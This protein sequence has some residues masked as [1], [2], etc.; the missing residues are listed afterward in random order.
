MLTSVLSVLLFG[1][2]PA[3]RMQSPDHVALSRLAIASPS[4]LKAHMEQGLAVA[5]RV[6]A[7]GVLIT[8]LTTGQVLYQ[9]YSDVRRPMASLTKLMTAIVIV[10][11]HRLDE[12]VAV[13]TD[14]S[15]MDGDIA[16]LPPGHHFT[17]GDLLSALLIPS[18]NDAAEALAR[19]HSG[20]TEAFV[21]AMNERARAIGLE[22]TSFANPVG[23]DDLA[24]WSTPR[25]L[26]LLATFALR[27][28]EIKSRLG[29]RGKKILS[30]E[31]TEIALT[32]THAFLHADTSVI[33]GKTGTTKAAG[34]CLMSIVKLGNREYL[35]I[36][37]RSLQRYADMRIILDALGASELI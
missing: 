25:D 5:K 24:Q 6:S 19:F 28:P 18:A 36:L 10:E 17:V 2:V 15:T 21:D 27:D 33:A 35:V 4:P 7:S 22:D 20:T 31:G 34:Q 29:S 8:D 23:F 3:V 1:M 12:W 13:P 32:H 26:A 11:N 14:I 37:L 30:R 16:R 9:K